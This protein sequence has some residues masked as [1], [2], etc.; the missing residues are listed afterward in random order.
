MRFK[1]DLSNYI[2][3]Q[4]LLH[5]RFWSYARHTISMHQVAGAACNSASS[6]LQSKAAWPGMCRSDSP[7]WRAQTANGASRSGTPQVAFCDLGVRP[8]SAGSLLMFRHACTA[9]A[10]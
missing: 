1:R 2:G 6:L 8:E 3:W 4:I 10:F 7:Q 9:V 5:G